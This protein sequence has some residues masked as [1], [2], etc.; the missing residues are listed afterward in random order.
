M[1]WF[2]ALA[3]DSQGE[4]QDKSWGHVGCQQDKRLEIQEQVQHVLRK[5]QNQQG[6]AMLCPPFISW[7]IIHFDQKL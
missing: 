1:E 3:Q 2:L 7:F 4:C 5:L 6:C